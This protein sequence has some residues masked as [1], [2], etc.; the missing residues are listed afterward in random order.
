MDEFISEILSN[1][2]FSKEQKDYLM[3]CI[4]SGMSYNEVKRI[5]KKELDVDMMKRVVNYY[6]RKK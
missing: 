5:A 2:D 4:E 3:S 6:E 1:K